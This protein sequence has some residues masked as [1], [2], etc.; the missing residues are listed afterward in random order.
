V[1]ENNRFNRLAWSASLSDEAELGLI[2]GG[3]EDGSLDIW[4]PDRIIQ[5]GDGLVWRKQVHAGSIKAL[6]YNS[7]QTNLLASGSANAEVTCI[8]T[9]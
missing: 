8:L 7:L 3:M 1:F 6:D 4:N 5:G 2:A 9:L